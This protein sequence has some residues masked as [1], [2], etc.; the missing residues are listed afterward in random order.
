ME[1]GLQMYTVRDSFAKD[2]LRTLDQV[3]AIGY[4]VIEMAN[5][6]AEIDP[7]TGFGINA[8]DFKKKVDDL[9]IKVIGAHFMPSEPRL[10]D[11][12]YHDD[13]AVGKVI[14]FYADLGAKHLSMPI[15][16]Y[17]TK[18]YLLRRCELYNKI[19]AKCHNAGIRFLYHNHYHEFQRFD[20][21]FMLDIILKN[22]DERF[23]GVELDAY[24]TFRG[25]L[26]PVSKIQQ[27]S[28]RIAIIH[29][30]D[31]PLDQVGHLNAWQVLNQ[32]VPVDWKG[33]HDAIK[34]DQFIEVGD[35]IIKIQ[36]VIDA[37]NE[38]G[39]PYILVEQDY[40][41]L[42]EIES[43]RLSMANFGKMRGLAHYPH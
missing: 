7:G 40:T 32:D 4:K 11:S 9:G 15:D 18:D 6:R 2:P 10:I 21:E 38:A 3:W 23:V 36:D 33:F 12:F 34:P 24:W 31:Y 26:D 35:G 17:P 41:K 22:T 16:F 8:D 29:E 20:K 5:H 43:I 39:V 30:K 27:Y 25:A 19:G 13:I 1:I 42:N 14:D 28:K 37:G